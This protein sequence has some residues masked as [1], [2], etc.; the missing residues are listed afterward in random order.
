MIPSIELSGFNPRSYAIFYFE[1]SEVWLFC[2]M[3]VVVM[4]H[5]LPEVGELCII[6]AGGSGKCVLWKLGKVKIAAD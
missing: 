6:G 4:S 5:F 1:S 2:L 3:Q